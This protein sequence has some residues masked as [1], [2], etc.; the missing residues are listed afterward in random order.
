MAIFIW[1]PNWVAHLNAPLSANWNDWPVTEEIVPA[2]WGWL[3]QFF[4]L[5]RPANLMVLLSHLLA[6]LS[7]WFV[8]REMNA[9]PEYVFV[10]AVA[11]GLS[12][13][14]FRE[15]PATSFPDDVLAF[16]LLIVGL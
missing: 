6:G 8:G 10:G 4:G 12:H 14:V 16:I 15:K 11:Y 5:L 13:F 7:F 1:W 2:L 3:G 9:R